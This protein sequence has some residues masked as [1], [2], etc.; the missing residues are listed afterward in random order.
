VLEQR[1]EQF[2]LPIRVYSIMQS[3]SRDGFDFQVINFKN[4]TICYKK[5]LDYIIESH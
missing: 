2:F 5:M 4:K 3:I 1:I